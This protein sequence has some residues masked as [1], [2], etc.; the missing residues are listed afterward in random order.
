MTLTRSCRSVGKWQ[1]E[2]ITVRGLIASVVGVQHLKPH[3]V[4]IMVSNVRLVKCAE[5][6]VY[7]YMVCVG[8]NARGSPVSPRVCVRRVTTRVQ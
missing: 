6:R 1:G 2:E 7:G 3:G 5:G 4:V 8:L